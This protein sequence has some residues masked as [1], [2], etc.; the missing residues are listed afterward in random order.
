MA[1]CKDA[2]PL[3][4]PL[5]VRTVC[6]QLGLPGASSPRTSS[7]VAASARGLPGEPRTGESS[8]GRMIVLIPTLL[9]S[10]CST[11]V[12]TAATCE[13]AWEVCCETFSTKRSSIPPQVRPTANVSLSLLTAVALGA[14]RS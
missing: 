7:A 1:G 12:A 3:A 11:T 4:A 8:A 10:G 14:H 6:E 13:R 5:T 9:G 2:H